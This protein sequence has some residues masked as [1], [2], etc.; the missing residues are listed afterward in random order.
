MT[1]QI[2]VPYAYLTQQFNPDNA[3]YDNVIGDLTELL[4]HGQFTLGPELERFEQAWAERCGTKFAVGV[5]SGTDAIKLALAAVGVKGGDHVITQVNTFPATVGAILE[6]GAIPDLVDCGENQLINVPQVL[7]K[8]KHDTKAIVP[9]W[10]AGDMDDVGLISKKGLLDNVGAPIIEDACQAIGS[11]SYGVPAGSVGKAA[12]FSLH[13]LKNV[14][15]WGDGGVVT[16]SDIGVYEELKLLRNHGLSSR[17]VWDKP[18]YNS[19][20]D[21]I[22]AIVGY[23]VLRDLDWS[24]NR[25]IA[26]AGIYDAELSGLPSVSLMSRNPNVLHSFHLYTI[27]CDRR[28]RLQ[29]YLESQ[30][31]ETKVHYPTPLHMQPAL[32]FLRHKIDD[33]PVALKLSRDMLSLPIH[34]YLTED[35]IGYTIDR[36]KSF[37]S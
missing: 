15:V 10:W 7:E 12:A 30:G 35:Q 32:R 28:D 2:K 4:R 8:I 13:P 14:N 16:T 18:G 36:I 11:R 26:N 19:R 24:L 20:L 34:E 5:A 1:T 25:R 29:D 22:H 31:V 23:Y 21:T 6:L 9:V 27:R 3:L 37:Y 17:D 33:F